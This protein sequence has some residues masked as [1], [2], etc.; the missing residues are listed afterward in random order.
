MHGI[1]PIEPG[2]RGGE[3]ARS[4]FVPNPEGVAGEPGKPAPKWKAARGSRKA[5]PA[6]ASEVWRMAGACW[7]A[8]IAMTGKPR[9][10]SGRRDGAIGAWLGFDSFAAMEGDVLAHLDHRGVWRAYSAEPGFLA[11]A[12]RD[13]RHAEMSALAREDAKDYVSAIWI[14][15]EMEAACHDTIAGPIGRTCS[16]GISSAFAR[17]D[18]AKLS[19]ICEAM[20]DSLERHVETMAGPSPWPGMTRAEAEWAEAAGRDLRRIAGNGPA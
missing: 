16:Y 17:Q 11:A 14:G 8:G 12:M 2:R 4:L 5:G 10:R 18:R 1:D 20:A 6:E 7:V 3:I 15:R 19:A 13:S 9:V